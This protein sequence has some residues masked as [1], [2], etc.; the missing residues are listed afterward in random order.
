MS[1][2][3]EQKIHSYC[4]WPI[5]EPIKLFKIVGI[6]NNN[7]LTPNVGYYLH[8]RFLSDGYFSILFSP[9][10]VDFI[11][12]IPPPCDALTIPSPFCNPEQQHLPQPS[13]PCPPQSPPPMVS[14]HLI[15]SG[16]LMHGE[17][18][19]T[20]AATKQPKRSKNLNSR[21]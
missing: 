9:N 15:T 11:S 8:S 6:S 16:F 7:L 14:S 19:K 18:N 21:R 5:S 4:Q 12:G 2:G 1:H 13:Q 17:L 3:T 10:F 20:K